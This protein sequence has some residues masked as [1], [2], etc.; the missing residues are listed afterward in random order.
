MPAG[1]EDS[2]PAS[3]VPSR[4]PRRA[5]Y[6]LVPLCSVLLTL[7]V[8]EAGLALFHPVP[9]SIESN[10]YYEADPDTGFRLKPLSVGHFHNGI[11]AAVNAQGHR[12][13]PV[14]EPKPDGVFRILLLGDSFTAGSNVGQDEVYGQVLERLLDADGPG[15]VEVVNAGTGGWEPFQ[16]AQ[17]FEQHGRAL[18]PDL[19]LVGFY[20]G[21]DTYNQLD[22]VEKL[23]TAVL[24]RRI[25]HAAA[26][27]PWSSLLVFLAT[28]SDLARLAIQKGPGERDFSRE[29]CDQLTEE[30]LAVQRGWLATHLRRDARREALA[31]NGMRQME[32]IAALAAE[33]GVRLV[34]A[35]LPDE[36]QVNPALRRALVPPDALDA[37]DFAM[38]QSMLLEKLAAAG[39][40]AVDL[41]P[42]FLADPRCLYMNDTHWTA[43]GHL[44]A[45][46]TLHAALA[47]YVD[48]AR[49]APV[50]AIGASGDEPGDGGGDDG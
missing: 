11:A 13:D 32:R 45:A 42:A 16:Y 36:I 37:Y 46:Q 41:L 17:Y 23:G 40:G 44:L 31:A 28:H 30:Y 19:V 9:F 47:P 39:V 21:N 33:N 26:E 20:A 3:P 2:L 43:E 15:K 12:D 1:K 10:M 38:P 22:R 8:L 24:G 5:F 6:V 4:R 27:S 48:G 7:A 35:I 50:G 49:R 25:S 34:V 29:R 18:E 14:A